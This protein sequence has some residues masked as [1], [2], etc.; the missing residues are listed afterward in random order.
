M[1]LCVG[2]YGYNEIVFRLGRL[3]RLVIAFTLDR[4]ANLA[5]R[6]GGRYRLRIACDI[7]LTVETG[8]IA[9]VAHFGSGVLS[10]SRE[11]AS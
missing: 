8:N 6:S 11:L 2:R 4:R 9:N 1:S 10:S 3:G 7:R 5:N